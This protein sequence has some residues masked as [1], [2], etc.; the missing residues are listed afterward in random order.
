MANESTE[1]NVKNL[2]QQSMLLEV[3]NVLAVGDKTEKFSVVKRTYAD[4]RQAMNVVFYDKKSLT[5]FE[6][7]YLSLESKGM[8]S[9]KW[10]FISVIEHSAKIV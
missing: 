4:D 7:T 5:V 3:L 6:S 10:E 9:P 1:Y 8:L 2:E